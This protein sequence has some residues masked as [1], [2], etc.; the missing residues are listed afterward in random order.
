M[1]SYFNV[2]P[3]SFDNYFVNSISFTLSIYISYPEVHEN[4]GLSFFAYLKIMYKHILTP[5][6]ILHAFTEFLTTSIFLLLYIVILIL[7]D[8]QPFKI[9]TDEIVKNIRTLSIKKKL[10]KKMNWRS[11]KLQSHY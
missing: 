11:L 3:F 9:L 2:H 8:Y 6:V 5:V 10:D 7:S 4:Q 1:V